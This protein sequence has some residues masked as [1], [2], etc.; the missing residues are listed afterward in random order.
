[1]L[2][3]GVLISGR[4]TNLQAIID[5]IEDGR[6]DADIE[7]VLSNT[8]SAHGLERAAAAG[9]ATTVVDHKSFAGREPFDAAMVD[10][11]KTAGVEW[12]VLAGF[13]RI[14]TPVFL[15]AFPQR[16]IN[17]H[18]ALCPSFAGIDAQAQALDYGVRV[19]GCT[20]HLVDQGVDTGPILSQAVVPVRQDDNRDTLAAR[21]LM[22]EHELLTTT[23][24]WIAEGRLTTEPVAGAGGD[25]LRVLLRGVDP[26]LFGSWGEP[27]A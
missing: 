9:I 4:G 10:A 26:L 18:P 3:L 22:R 24:Q 6:L 20:V 2:A 11:L 25:R 17:M 7:L 13:M 23:L 1:M 8:A 15:N 21:L 16:V 14:V 27:N 5:A 12:V 19:T